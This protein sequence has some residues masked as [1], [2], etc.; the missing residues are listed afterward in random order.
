MVIPSEKR[1]KRDFKRECDRRWTVCLE[2]IEENYVNGQS[3][4]FFVFKTAEK[5]SFIINYLDATTRNRTYF[6][7]GKSQTR[8]DNLVI[9]RMQHCCRPLS[10]TSQT[11]DLE[12]NHKYQEGSPERLEESRA[13]SSQISK[14]YEI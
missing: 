1:R 10:G 4:E 13:K 11:E 2:T 5:P 12:S 6:K 8:T 9:G 14:M 3:H 7:I